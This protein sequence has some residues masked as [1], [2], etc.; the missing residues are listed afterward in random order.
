VVLLVPTAG[1]LWCELVSQVGYSATTRQDGCLVDSAVA[2][3]LETASQ[4]GRL[5][6]TV[7]NS[8][9]CSLVRLSRLRT[10]GRRVKTVPTIV[11]AP[12]SASTV[13]A[14]PVAGHAVPHVPWVLAPPLE[15]APLS[16]TAGRNGLQ[17]YWGA[18]P[19]A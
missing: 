18:C 9:G 19:P 16:G 14:R 6:R 8:N 10:S 15:P 2:R 17:V 11:G 5:V 4:S 1:R 13:S 7:S 12:P 3:P